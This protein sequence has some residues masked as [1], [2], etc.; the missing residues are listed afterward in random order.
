MRVPNELLYRFNGL[1]NPCFVSREL[2]D[3]VDLVGWCKVSGNF[4]IETRED[5]RELLHCTLARLDP[6]C[7]ES[8]FQV[9]HQAQQDKIRA[10]LDGFRIDTRRRFNEDRKRALMGLKQARRFLRDCGNETDEPVLAKIAAAIEDHRWD[11]PS[12]RRHAGHQPEPWLKEVRK[13]LAQLKISN[14]LREDLL[15]V[16]CLTYRA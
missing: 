9:L 13:Q 15:S 5:R 8:V 11:G 3:N 6:N 2:P 1:L 7:L 16:V 4:D 12:R 14:E 10:H